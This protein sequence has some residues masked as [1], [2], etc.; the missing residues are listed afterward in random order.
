MRVRRRNR[1]LGSTA[2]EFA[3][4]FPVF[5]AL[6]ACAL[7]GGRFVVSRMMLA[8]AVTVGARAA[9]L[10]NATTSSVQ[11]AVVNAAPMLHLTTGQVEITS[12]GATATLPLAVGS[13]VTVSVGVTNSSNKYQFKSLI[14][15]K[16]SP[17]ATR[18]W[19]AQATMTTR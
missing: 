5:F 16:F 6:I 4:V 7:E 12:G 1:Q 19:S 2:V 11:T 15:V 10:S 8:Y 14:P 17:F 9:T 3:L 18:T 13:A